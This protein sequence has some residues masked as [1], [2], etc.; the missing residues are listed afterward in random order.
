[1]ELS[2]IPQFDKFLYFLSLQKLTIAEYLFYTTRNFNQLSLLN[3]FHPF[4]FINSYILKYI[5]YDLYI[6]ILFVLVCIFIFYFLNKSSF[7][8]KYIIFW[9]IIFL[10]I[11]LFISHVSL[12]LFVLCAWFLHME[13]NNH[14]KIY[15]L[16]ISSVIV[17]FLSLWY[18][19]FIIF[20]LYF[21]IITKK[22]WL[23]LFLLGCF[24]F[25]FFFWFL[26]YWYMEGFSE[27]FIFYFFDLL[28]SIF[29][30]NEKEM[31][32]SKV[33]FPYEI[34]FFLFLIFYWSL[35]LS[36]FLG[37]LSQSFNNR[38][39]DLSKIFSNNIIL[40]FIM[41]LFSLNIFVSFNKI[42]F[43]FTLLFFTFCDHFLIEKTI[44]Y[45]IIKPL[46]FV[47]IFFFLY[48]ISF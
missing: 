13:E 34:V 16:M 25:T 30:M 32:H 23:K 19:P 36:V 42:N 46:F 21:S 1:M 12:I 22:P 44:K 41:L 39:Y 31:I 18:T 8:K 29:F 6:A 5:S 43:Y 2:L 37:N 7:K 10:L 3:Q 40:L 24:V 38:C 26:S 45:K 9:F 15:F 27:Q 28:K 4:F 33:Y 14:I 11:S 17:C 47:P 20:F 35:S 48:N